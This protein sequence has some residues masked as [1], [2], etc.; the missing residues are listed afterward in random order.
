MKNIYIYVLTLVSFIGC[1]TPKTIQ[2]MHVRNMESEAGHTGFYYSLPRTVLSIDVEVRKIEHLPGPFS[3]YAERLLGLKDVIKTRS[4]NFELADIKINTFAE[5]DP[6]QFYFV[7]YDPEVFKDTTFYISY[8]ESGLLK[9]VN[10]SFTGDFRKTLCYDSEYGHFG[11]KSTFNYFIEKNLKEKVDTIVEM[12]VEDT[13][14]VERQILQ[15][16][17]VEKGTETKAKEITDFIIKLRNQKMD[18]ISG[19]P[20]ISYS[21]ETLEYMYTELKDIEK[22]YLE[23]FTGITN[24]SITKYRVAHLPDKSEVNREFAIFRFCPKEGVLPTSDSEKGDVVTLELR[25]NESTRQP[26]VF[27]NR[28]ID[29]ENSE[30]GFYYRIPEYSNIII[31][32][33]NFV[34]AEARFLIN[35]FGIITY[36]PAE[37]L[38]VEFYPNTGFIKSVGKKLK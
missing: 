4:E 32:N 1:S 36:L 16:S 9:S 11:S 3:E 34:K 5:P 20:E 21:K 37:H 38:E 24:T 33:N 13:V 30:R 29:P 25:R 23:L 8:S 6:T 2:V 27:I 31:R 15:K 14:I 10:T 18:L 28:N 22:K 35:Q 26:E 7:K 17:W 19:F 12:L